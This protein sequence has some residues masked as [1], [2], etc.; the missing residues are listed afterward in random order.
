M[1]WPYWIT[2]AIFGVWLLTPT[3]HTHI[4]AAILLWSLTLILFIYFCRFYVRPYSVDNNNLCVKKKRIKPLGFF[5]IIILIIVSYYFVRALGG[6]VIYF[7]WCNQIEN[8]KAIRN[9]VKVQ[10][11]RISRMKKKNKIVVLTFFFFLK[12]CCLPSR[13]SESTCTL[14]FRCHWYF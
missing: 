14:P 11:D 1:K 3:H 9:G 5:V 7:Y 10:W 12:E 4:F 2:T 13:D 8:W 6:L